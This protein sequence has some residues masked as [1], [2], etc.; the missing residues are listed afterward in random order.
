MGPG[1]ANRI[2]PA[3]KTGSLNAL[4]KDLQMR[5][6]SFLLCLTLMT[7]L[8]AQPSDEAVAAARLNYIDGNH[9]EA[10]AVLRPAAEAGD[11]VAQNILGNA[12]ELGNGVAADLETAVTWYD[13]A[14]E[15]DFDRALYNLGLIYQE[16]DPDRARAYYE[17]AVALDYP[18]AMNNL[19]LMY[20]NGAFG[21]PDFDAAVPLFQAAS[22]MDHVDAMNTLADLYFYGDGV[23][24]DLSETLALYRRVADLGDASGFNNLGVMYDYGYGVTKDKMAALS[25]YLTAAERGHAQAMINLAYFMIE[26][27]TSWQDLAQGYVWCLRGMA[28]AGAEDAEAF[29]EDCA[30]LAE[31]AGADAVAL[32]TE[33]FAAK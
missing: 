30:S 29:A 20:M 10:L 26:D 18:F 31:T 32:A 33:R 14:A 25:L 2:D 13:R 9:A 23:E 7:P 24:E 19:G 17:R 15:Q 21:D 8:W 4:Q 3:G 11:P 6:L 5:I 28:A 12:Y 27:E 22:D 1:G 16:T